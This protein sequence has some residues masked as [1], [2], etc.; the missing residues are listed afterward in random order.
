[1]LP[2]YDRN[3]RDLPWRRTRD[4]YRIYVSEIMLQQTR[5]G[6]VIG[7]YERFLQQF[8]TVRALAEADDEALNKAWEGLGYYSR[9]RNLKRAAIAVCEN[10]GGVFPS[11]YAN[12]RTLTGAGA[13][14]AGAVASIAGGE[15]IAAVDG[16]V[17]RILARVLAYAQPADE[18]Y[19]AALADFLTRA[20]PDERCGDYTQSFMDLGS[21]VCLPAKP[22]CGDCPLRERCAAYATGVQNDLPVRAQKAARKLEL[23]T[24]FVLRAENRI[25][26]QKRPA[27][28]VL[29]RLWELPNALG[30]F[31]EQQ[32]INAIEAFGGEIT[33]AFTVRHARHVFTHL[34]WDM[35]IYDAAVNFNGTQFTLSDPYDPCGV[36]LPTAFRK[37]L[38]IHLSP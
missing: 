28:G 29:A 21:A 1:M 3:K 36:A 15:R 13:Y 12:L 7:Y 2:W 31:T 5:V 16:N 33:G 10:H 25:A 37:C 22:L 34:E 6:A 35:L 26:V 20:Y 27:T 17:L 32:A 24:V 8:P 30:H 4:P 9:A 11:D 14:T 19:K 23:R 38:P 18:T